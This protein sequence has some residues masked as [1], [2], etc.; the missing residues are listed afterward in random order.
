MNVKLQIDTR[1]LVKLLVVLAAFSGAMLI[2]WRILPVLMIIII[3]FFFAIALN[4]PVSLIS[5]I[6]PRHSRVFATSI[7]YIIVVSILVGATLLFVPPVVKQAGI[8]INALPSAIEHLSSKRTFVANLI[9]QYHLK[10]FLDQFVAGIQRQSGDIAKGIGINFVTGVTSVVSGFITL[11]TIFVL[12]FMMLIEGP[13]WFEH[14]WNLYHN[15]ALMERHKKLLHR[16]NQVV[17]SYVNGQVLVAVIAA[18][19]T[20]AALLVLGNFFKVPI[21]AVLP[22]GLMMFF[23]TLIPMIG[24]TLGATIVAIVL[25]FTDIAGALMFTAYFL[26]YQQIENNIIQPTVQSRTVELSALVVLVSVI[27]GIVLIGPAGGFLAVPVAGC[28]RVL[29]MDYLE[30]RKFR[31][32]QTVI[33]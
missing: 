17:V 18:L 26:I 15:H 5:R 28:I 6:L 22:L 32:Q 1:T 25:A 21:N 8:V 24:L 23:S 11:L 16:M 31:K 4:K 7:S 29:L 9:N 30:H 2:I 33:N 12:T 27:I 14:L 20:S 13:H 19:A 10:D 3:S